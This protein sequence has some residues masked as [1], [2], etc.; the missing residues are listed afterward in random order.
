M[1][2]AKFSLG[3]ETIARPHANTYSTLHRNLVIAYSLDFKL[4]PYGTICFVYDSGGCGLNSVYGVQNQ[5]YDLSTT[6]CHCVLCLARTH[7]QWN[8]T[9]LKYSTQQVKPLFLYINIS[10]LKW[11]TIFFVW[12]HFLFQGLNFL[13]NNMQIWALKRMYLDK[14]VTWSQNTNYT[15]TGLTQWG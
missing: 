15:C 12:F 14:W 13:W 2:V 5:T 11:H 6:I 4:L 8:S 7:G 3:S 10:L 9:W 1:V